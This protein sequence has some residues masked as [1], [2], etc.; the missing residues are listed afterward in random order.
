M[1]KLENLGYENTAE[2]M[3]E[4]VKK[5]LGIWQR[6]VYVTGGELELTNSY[7]SLMT[8]KLNNGSE[9]LSTLKDEKSTLNIRSDKYTGLDVELRRN[10][11]S[12]SERLLG[13]DWLWMVVMENIIF[14]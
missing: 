7:Y 6:L 8:W 14:D 4:V 9:E 13:I 12:N 5:C 10:S 2:K 3:I 11:Y 1:V